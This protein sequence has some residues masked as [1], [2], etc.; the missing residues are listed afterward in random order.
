M[1]KLLDTGKI[2]L[3]VP[4]AVAIVVAGATFA[5]AL[6]YARDYGLLEVPFHSWYVFVISGLL[7]VLIAVLDVIATSLQRRLKEREEEIHCLRKQVKE[8]EEEIRC[9]KKRLEGVRIPAVRGFKEPSIAEHLVLVQKLFITHSGIEYVDVTPLPGGYGG[10]TTLMAWIKR[11]NRDALLPK[12]YVLKLGPQREMKDE[13]DKYDMY[14]R[15]HI[16]NV[17][18]FYCYQELREWAG[19]AYE[20]AGEGEIQNF[21]QFYEGHV[22]TE[23]IEIIQMVYKSLK[24]GRDGL[25]VWYGDRKKCQEIHEEIY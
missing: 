25:P 23:L 17:P 19:I 11:E 16:S 18:G 15:D 20:F 7:A 4:F 21:H 8:T 24:V 14:V 13:K 2:A 1:K 5:F 12:P 10:S 3:W 6:P 22:T 9:L